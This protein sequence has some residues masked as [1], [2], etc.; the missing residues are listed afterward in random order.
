MSNNSCLMHV[1]LC[2]YYLLFPL[3]FV[4]SFLFPCVLVVFEHVL[5]IHFTPTTIPP[6]FSEKF[7]GEGH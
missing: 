2:F 3:S 6:G 4:H 5:D 7:E 1:G